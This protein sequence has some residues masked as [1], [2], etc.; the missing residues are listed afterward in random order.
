MSEPNKGPSHRVYTLIPRKVDGKDENFWL[1]IGSAFE[2]KDGKGYN[3][4][5]E[6]LPLDGRL[7]LRDVQDREPEPEP[8]PK[9][10]RRR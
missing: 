2:H 1:N 10:S 5:L 7:V 8:E 3:L 6:A 4:V 9:S